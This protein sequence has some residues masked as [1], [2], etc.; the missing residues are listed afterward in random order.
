MIVETNRYLGYPD[1]FSLPAGERVVFHVSSAERRG[2]VAVV[3]LRCAD[4]DATGP[5]L[6]YDLLDSPISGLHDFVEQA[7]LGGEICVHRPVI[8]EMVAA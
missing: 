4:S 8:I 1:R 7:H 5:G 6:R 3:R 2:E